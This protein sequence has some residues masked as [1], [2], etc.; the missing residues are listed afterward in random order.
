[1]GGL[2]SG[3]SAPDRRSIAWVNAVLLLVAGRVGHACP[4]T[5][6]ATARPRGPTNPSA[7]RARRGRGLVIVPAMGEAGGGSARVA[8]EVEVERGSAE[9]VA[10]RLFQLGAT[11]VAEQAAEDGD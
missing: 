7:D 6:D 3:A 5:I 1:R 11:A 9:L 4:A 10:D 2:T 8:V